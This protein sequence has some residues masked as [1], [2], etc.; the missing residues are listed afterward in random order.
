VPNNVRLHTKPIIE[1]RR[2][3][4]IAVPARCHGA[5]PTDL[6][7]CIGAYKLSHSKDSASTVITLFKVIQGHRFWYQS[8]ARICDFLLMNNCTSFVSFAIYIAQC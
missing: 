4:A 7:Y 3:Y 6:Q 8:E 1:I 5:T 2:M